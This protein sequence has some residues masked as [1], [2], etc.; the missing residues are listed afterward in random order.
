MTRLRQTEQEALTAWTSKLSALQAEFQGARFAVRQV[1][2]NKQQAVTKQW[3]RSPI[4]GQVVD[5]RVV[6]V[7]VD[8]VTLEVVLE[9][10]GPV[11]RGS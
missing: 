8:G 9:R 1:E 2:A 7:S 6:E 11:L 10:A 3:V 5:V 4:S